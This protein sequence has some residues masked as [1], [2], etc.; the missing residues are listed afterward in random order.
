MISM[1]LI[2]SIREMSRKGV[3]NAEIQRRTGVSQPT[4]RKYLEMDDFSPAVPK[5]QARASKLDPYKPFVDSIL[6]DDRNIWRKQRHSAR[7]I[8]E[9]LLAETAYDGKYGTV[10]NYVR[11]RRAE[12]AAAEGRYLKLVWG[13]GEA[14][15]DFGDVDVVC[16]GARVRMHFFVLSF[17]YSNM[18]F[19][20][21]F[22]GQT[23]ECVCQGLRDIF[24]HIGGVPPRIVLD[25][26]TGAGRRRGSKVTEAELFR[27]MRAHYGFEATYANP[28]SGNEKGS[29][30]RKVYW[31]RQ[32]LFTPAPAVD[33]VAAFNALLLAACDEAGACAHYEK[34]ATWGELFERDRAALL[35]LPAKPFACVRY[36]TGAAVDKRGDAVVDG[37][38]RYHVGHGLATRTVTVAY[39]AHTV[40]FADAAG[41]V[42][43]EHPRRFGAPSN[44][45]DA[46]SQLALLAL[47]P[48]AWRNSAVRA[49]MPADVASH[50]D[51][52]EASARADLL[53]AMRRWC[54]SETV[55]AVGAAIG[56]VL[57]ATGRPGRPTS[58]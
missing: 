4:T 54:R 51:A 13:P 14:Q 21:L 58:R 45:P 47:K 30:G 24:E 36:V 27:R 6:E 44:G 35:P 28:R 20:R 8:Y 42:V 5:A 9:R 12:M 23:S 7:R 53:G 26:A 18:E 17:P 33:D 11:A 38:H 43:A 50:M 39:G 3:S 57:A 55:A 22:A 40:A 56:E 25:N 10:K 15:A 31:C 16:G 34:R 2:E 49:A 37:G 41:E 48:G 1:P 52:M 19:R 32:H 46:A 29:V